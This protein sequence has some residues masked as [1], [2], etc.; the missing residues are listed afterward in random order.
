KDR[1]LA[2]V[3]RQGFRKVLVIGQLIL[4]VVMLVGIMTIYRQFDFIQQQVEGYQKEQVFKIIA[5]YPDTPLNGQEAMDQYANTL[6]VLKNS[7][8]S[9]SAIQYVSR[10]NGVSIIDDKNAGPSRI[11][12]TGYPEIKDG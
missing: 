12:W 6:N 8:L 9:S 1:Q 2:G 4:A 10:V 7:L 5:P 11:V 3:S